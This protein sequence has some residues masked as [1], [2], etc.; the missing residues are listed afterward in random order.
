MDRK[1]LEKP[2]ESHQVKQR[3]GSHGQVLDFVEGQKLADEL[4][5]SK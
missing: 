5:A 4:A 1:L 2:F 3:D